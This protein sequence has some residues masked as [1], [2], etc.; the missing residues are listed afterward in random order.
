VPRLLKQ[1]VVPLAVLAVIAV[2]FVIAV[3]AP[4]DSDIH[5]REL[6]WLG[7]LAAWIEEAPVAASADCAAAFDRRVGSAP[8]E[9]L[10]PVA[11]VA[12]NGCSSSDSTK[13]WQD[14]EWHL[15][16][17]LITS[18][19][20]A[21]RTT[22]EPELA[23]AVR[24]VIGQAIRVH[25]WPADS[26]QPL[27]EEWGILDR[28]DFWGAYAFADPPRR[29]IH[30]SPHVCVPLRRFFTGSYAPHLNQ[31]SLDLAQ[32]LVMLAHNAEH[33]R[34][35]YESEAVVECYAM[36]GVRGF[37]SEAGRASRYANA[38]ARLAWD[39]AYPQD[40]APFRTPDCRNGGRLDRHPQSSLWP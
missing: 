38:L 36:Q 35:S 25:C 19:F 39:I 21:A 33:V 3:W 28:D 12:R 29:A 14:V 17:N 13:H 22:E 34:D 1:L 24:D 31:E 7:T 4:W 23:V 32:A 11:R 10:R 9:R 37:V 16:S 26:W 40:A 18:R 8:S 6:A 20:A 30:L 2:G 5:E 15:L 27:A